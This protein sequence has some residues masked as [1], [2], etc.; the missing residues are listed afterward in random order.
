MQIA[1][2]PD[3]SN[4]TAHVL[5]RR[6]YAPSLAASG[7]AIRRSKVVGLA[8]SVEAQ[9][10][11]A[12]GKTPNYSAARRQP[13]QPAHWPYF[14]PRVEDE[15]TGSARPDQPYLPHRT[16]P[17]VTPAPDAGYAPYKAWADFSGK[18]IDLYA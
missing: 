14:P 16:P 12:P 13:T 3:S 10:A 15:A 17:V 9:V 5:K 7:E 1:P 6:M 2:I 4:L 11:P 18:L 8:Y